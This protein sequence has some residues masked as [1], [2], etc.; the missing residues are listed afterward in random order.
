M[1]SR[2]NRVAVVC[3]VSV[4]IGVIVSTSDSQGQC[5]P[6][7][8]FDGEA[9]FNKLGQAVA[10]AGDVDADGYDDII[11]GAYGYNDST[12]R[13][14]VYS[15]RSGELLKTFTGDAVQDHFGWSVDGA[16]DVNNDGYADLIVGAPY[17]DVAASAA[18]RVYVYSGFNDSLLYSYIGEQVSF[19]YFGWS[20]A[21]AGDVNNDGYDDFVIGAY[22][23]DDIAPAAGRMYVYSGLNGSLIFTKTGEATSDFFG[24]SVSG[25]GDVDNDGY[26]DVIVGAHEYGT[27]HGRV[28]VYSGQTQGTLYTFTGETTDIVFGFSVDGAGD[29]NFDGCD[30]IIVG[31]PENDGAGLNFGRA[32]V[33]SGLDADTL[34]RIEGEAG[35]DLFGQSVAG[36]GDVNG[37]NYSD[38]AVNAIFSDTGGTDAGRVYVYSGFDGS[39][40]HT[41]DGEAAL[42]HVFPVASAGDV[43]NDGSMD[44]VYGA[45]GSDSSGTDAGRA[46][47]YVFGDPDADGLDAGCDNCPRVANPGQE[48]LDLDGRGDACYLPDYLTPL[49]FVARDTLG[50]DPDMNITVIDPDGFS[51]GADSLGVTTN[52]IGASAAYYQLATNDSIVISEPKTGE[53]KM[54]A[55]SEAGTVL[56][57]RAQAAGAYIVGIRTDGTV[58]LILG[59][60]TQPA[61]GIVDTVA[62]SA[63]P[64]T[65]GDA[66]GDF[67]ITIGDVTFLISRIFSGGEA[68]DPEEAGD[69][70][71]DGSITIG[72]VTFLIARIFAG[73]EAPGCS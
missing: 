36:L 20:V 10:G 42:D 37:D 15:G 48:D 43:N 31:S 22:G 68:P 45:R 1:K 2:L 38:F 54:L 61:S 26:D 16:G 25:A 7:G 28:Y 64:Y 30:D 65:F 41:F 51:I 50:P 34:Y 58:E 6:E 23:N 5:P 72:D 69:A 27:R 29:V 52:T 44:L 18:G 21:G 32:Y 47:V 70:N 13:A 49:R 17:N 56:L 40:L 19:E 57:S 11:I 60:F 3:F 4:L 46:H 35:G 73:G 12:G 71:C 63:E 53:Y 14:Y 8:I 59:P 9:A 24:F 66:N 33:F 55:V 62:H 67:V 39:R